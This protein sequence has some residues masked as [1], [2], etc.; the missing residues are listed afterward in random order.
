MTVRI[1][2][3]ERSF[4]RWRYSVASAKVAPP[5]P[6]G[7]KG[8][9]ARAKPIPSKPLRKPLYLN[10]QVARPEDWEALWTIHHAIFVGATDC[11]GNV[12]PPDVHIN[13]IMSIDVEVI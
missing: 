10:H 13:Q 2:P 9:K 7:G 12:Q 5:A 11:H 6:L 4:E 1:A 8:G 3:P